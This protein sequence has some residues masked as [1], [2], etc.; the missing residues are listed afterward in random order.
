VPEFCPDGY[1]PILQAIARAAE[2]WFAEQTHKFEKAMQSQAERE[3]EGHIEQAVRAFS[4]P[5]YP[6]EFRQIAI[7]TVLRMRDLLHRGEL[8]AYYFDN[9]G[10][11]RVPRDFWATAEADDVFEAGVFWPFGR[12]GRVLEPGPNY[13]L[14]LQQLE[15][16]RLLRAEPAEKR[17][18]P[19]SKIPELVAA[20]REL[21]GNRQAQYE[22]LCE[23]PRFREFKVTR[24]DFREAARHL[25]R[26]G[27]RKSRQ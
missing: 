16:D 22:A 4:G 3:P 12:R 21:G 26:K 27:G 23:L 15:L 6:E 13:R 8:T 7:E 25:P 20:L 1:I 5:Q 10:L 18:L 9:Y 19:R 24:A 17:S 2:R 14:F 11:H